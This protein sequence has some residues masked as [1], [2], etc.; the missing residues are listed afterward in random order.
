MKFLLM[1]VMFYNGNIETNTT[2]YVGTEKGC[3]E[4]GKIGVDLIEGAFK[5]P[6]MFLCISKQ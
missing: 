1:I 4:A 3:E 5:V 2:E 6:S